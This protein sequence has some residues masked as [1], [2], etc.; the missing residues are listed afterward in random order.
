MAFPTFS[1]MAISC[2][3]PLSTEKF[4]TK[5]FGF[6]RARVVSLGT[7]REKAASAARFLYLNVVT[8]NDI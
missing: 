5:Y 7:D 4:Y 2:K 3:D 1:R 8:H 6:N